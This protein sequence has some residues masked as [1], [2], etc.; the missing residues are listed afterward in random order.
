MTNFPAR[1]FFLLTIFFAAQCTASP[2]SASRYKLFVVADG[3]YRVTASDLRRA[4]ARIAEID[5]ATVRLF[6]GDREIALH[7]LGVRGDFRFEFFGQASDSPYSAFTVYWLEWGGQAG[8]RMR[9]IPALPATDSPRTSARATVRADESALYIPQP[10]D[11]RASWFWHA[12]IAPATTTLAITLPFALAEPAELRVDVV[13]NSQDAANPDHRLRVFF[14]ETWLADETWDGQGA[15]VLAAQIPAEAIRAGANTVRLGAPGDTGAQADALLVRAVEATYTRR[16]IAHDEMLDLA[17]ER[18]TYRVEGFARAPDLF[19]LTAPDDPARIVGA[20]FADGGIGF[21]ADAARR[22]LIA[23]ERARLPV[24]RITPMPAT[25]VRERRADYVIVAPPDLLAAAQPLVRWREQHG[26]R[27]SVATPAEIY[28]AFGFGAESPHAIRAFLET[29][30]PRFALLLGKASYDYRDVLRA[31]NRNG[32]PTFLVTTPHLAQAA[33]DA[34][35]VAE[36]P[37]A[38]G[39]IP[40]QTP[41][42]VARVVEKI[43]AYESAPRGD[44]QTRALWIADAAEPG[45][46]ALANELA[47]LL[48]NFAAAKIDLAPYAGDVNAARV[49]VLAQWNVGARIV[50]YIGHG[51]LTTWAAGTLFDATHARQLRNGDRLPV[52]V[53]PTCLAGFFYHPTQDSLAEELLFAR[54]GGIVAGLV[55]TGLSVPHAQAALLRAF[56]A[57][58][59]GAPTWGEAVARAQRNMPAD[60]PEL[61]EV[62]ATFVWLGDPALRFGE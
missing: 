1:L 62:S 31:P 57:E 51:S 27:V 55:P 23:G 17:G 41:A 3:L 45:F 32:V 48:P 52:L 46:S 56:F 15:R 8:K 9:E 13:G 2:A 10:G 28:D 24:V 36:T 49:Q 53:A 25:N 29:L 21:H 26:L 42:Q 59:F 6:R 14:N 47:A 58:L 61:R 40:A 11:A 7:V 16:L 18:A 12:L 35:F 60:S 39:R 34:W 50:T 37:T 4:G 44:W 19:D 38:L 30:A 22:W 33:S 5:P 20:P 43:I 54:D